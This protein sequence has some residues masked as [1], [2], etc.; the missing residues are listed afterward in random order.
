MAKSITTNFITGI[1]KHTSKS[2]GSDIGIDEVMK[3]SKSGVLNED[4]FKK[5]NDF[6]SKTEIALKFINFAG[7]LTG[8]LIDNGNNSNK[9]IN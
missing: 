4:A 3:A 2:L 9:K 1:G 7:K 5:I 6:T 8:S